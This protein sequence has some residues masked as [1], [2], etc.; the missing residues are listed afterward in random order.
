MIKIPK[1][2]ACYF[3]INQSEESEGATTLTPNVVFKNSYLKAIREFRS[4]VHKLPI[5]Y[6]CLC[7]NHS[8]ASDSL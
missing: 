8:V 1:T 2:L 4:F 7:V 6:P 3:A 5:H